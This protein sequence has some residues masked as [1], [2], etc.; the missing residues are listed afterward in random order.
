MGRTLAAASGIWLFNIYTKY[1][2][3]HTRCT[4]TK[5]SLKR[6]GRDRIKNNE[7]FD[8]VTE[9]RQGNAT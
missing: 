7:A 9:A 4:S 1:T 3:T 8:A 2:N 6:I 5:E